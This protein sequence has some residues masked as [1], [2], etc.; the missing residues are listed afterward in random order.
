MT[1]TGGFAPGSV[2]SLWDIMKKFE[3]DGLLGP[4]QVI[5]QLRGS[6]ENAPQSTAFAPWNKRHPDYL[7]ILPKIREAPDHLRRVDL[8]S[9]AKCA[10]RLLSEVTG[11]AVF[12]DIRSRIMALED[13]I[14]DELERRIVLIVDQ[15]KQ[16]FFKGAPLE[17]DVREAFPKAA[18]EMNEAARC[19]ATDRHTASVFHMMRAMEICVQRFG[20]KLHVPM[21]IVTK[22]DKLRD[23]AWGD[24]TNQIKHKINKRR[25][26]TKSQ[27][28][29]VVMFLAVLSKLDDVREAW[30]NPTMHP[31]EKSY[32]GLEAEDIFIRTCSFLRELATLF[33]PKKRQNSGVAVVAYCAP[34]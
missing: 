18:V 6:I 30:R 31:G 20:K 5:S 23:Q 19:I 1:R 14:R 7:R 4:C 34:R 12:N 16:E 27:K 21:S 29:Q 24:I 11:N 33:P 8:K 25:Q 13:A 32:N 10:D 28:Q 2:W 15:R 9:S 17:I 26:K 3:L 22:N